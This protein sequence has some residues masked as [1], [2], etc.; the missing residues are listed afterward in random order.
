MTKSAQTTKPTPY[1]IILSALY[2]Y[3]YQLAGIIHL[4]GHNLAARFLGIPSHVVWPVQRLV[5]GYG[6]YYNLDKSHSIMMNYVD[7]DMLNAS[8][9]PDKILYGYAGIVSQVRNV[10]TRSKWDLFSLSS[11]AADLHASSR[12]V[13]PVDSRRIDLG[14]IQQL[15]ERD[16]P[17]DDPVHSPLRNSLLRRRNGRLCLLHW[18]LPSLKRKP[19]YVILNPKNYSYMGY[20][21][22]SGDSRDLLNNGRD[23]HDHL[24]F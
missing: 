14:V 9:P 17:V 19:V 1:L 11:L 6:W 15:H 3:L 20:L 4:Y 22:R 24:F 16:V 12:V 21:L 5:P 7:D 10:A 2:I 23:L 8:D 13:L 18:C